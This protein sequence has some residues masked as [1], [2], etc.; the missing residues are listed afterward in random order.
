MNA[1][2]RIF[3]MLLNRSN[4]SHVSALSFDAYD[5]NTATIKTYAVVLAVVDRSARTAVVN[6]EKYSSTSSKHRTQTI[7]ALIEADYSITENDYKTNPTF[8]K[9]CEQNSRF[10]GWKN[11][12]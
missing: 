11:R 5:D 4:H 2:D 9:W 6:I 1:Q 3:E 7:R 10:A 8:I 12:G